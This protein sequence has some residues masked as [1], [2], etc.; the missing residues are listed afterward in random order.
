MNNRFSF[1]ILLT[2]A[3]I[4]NP[5]KEFSNEMKLYLKTPQAMIL[6]HDGNT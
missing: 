3:M 4:F 6:G 5:K 1:P 2:G